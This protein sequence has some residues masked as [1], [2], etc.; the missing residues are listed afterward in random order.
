MSSN[1]VAGAEGTAA[2]LAPADDTEARPGPLRALLAWLGRY[3]SVFVLL[4]AWE[5][6]ARSGLVNPRLFPSL[7][8]IGDELWRL[9]ESGAIYRHLAATLYRVVVGFALAAVGGVLL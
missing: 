3:Y 1:Q 2:T 6:L 5:V 8:T 9:I 4:A 7:V